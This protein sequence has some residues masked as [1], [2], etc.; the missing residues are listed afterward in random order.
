MALSQKIEFDLCQQRALQPALK[1]AKGAL[2]TTPVAKSYLI[3]LDEVGR[4]C[5]AGPVTAGAFCIA[6]DSLTRWQQ[7]P[8]EA[9]ARLNDSKKLA[10]SLRG[11]LAQ[12]LRQH[13]EATWSLGWVEAA[14]ID[15]LN[16]HQATLKAM[17]RAL[18]AVY[19]QLAIKGAKPANVCVLID[20]RW[21][22]PEHTLPA[23]AP[24]LIYQ[25]P[26]IAGDAQSMVI[27][28]ASVLAKVT[29][30][31]HMT[32]LA[33]THPDYGWMQNK[34]YGTL[35]HRQALLAL[36]ATREHRQ[37]FLSKILCGPLG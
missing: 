3:G 27:A 14:E 10:A 16:I 15:A 12:A 7:S 28:A 29:R 22:L 33:Q 2:T 31:A 30:D 24:G 19:G 26:V 21:R 25:K 1:P 4:G 20:G 34:G 17:A 11:S 18:E 37:T 5:L 9:L 23:A 8:P 13:P 32:Q 6:I 36:G 35:A